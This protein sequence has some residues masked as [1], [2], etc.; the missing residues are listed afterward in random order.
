MTTTYT[1]SISSNFGGNFNPAQFQKEITNNSIITTTIQEIDVDDDT[2]DIVFRSSLSAPELT[3][4]ENLVS[5]YIYGADPRLEFV[6]NGAYGSIATLS[7]SQT[8][9][10]T[11]TL[12]D[13]TDTIVSQ[14]NTATISNKTL[15]SSN[16][17]VTKGF[18]VIVDF[19]GTGDYTSISAAFAA[20]NTSVFVR[21]GIYYEFDDIILPDG[22][23]LSGEANAQVTIVFIGNKGIKVDGS[24]G[25]KYTTGTI[26]VTNG[27]SQVIGNGTS[28]TN[29]VPGNFILIGN[30]FYSIINIQNDTN[31]TLTDIYRGATMENQTYVAQQMLTAIAIDN[32]II[33]GST[34]VGL[35]LRGLRH[36]TVRSTAVLG[37]SPNIQIVD[38]GDSS[39]HT[40]IVQNSI[41]HGI[42]LTNCY[43]FLCDTINVFNSTG[44]GIRL[45]GDSFSA[46][47]ETCSSSCNSGNGFCLEGDSRSISMTDCVSKQNAIEGIC[48]L[49]NT[50]QITIESCIVLNNSSHGIHFTGIGNIISDCIVHENGSNG[51]QCG[52]NGI[53]KGNQVDKNGG[54][55]IDIT[56]ENLCNINGNRCAENITNGIYCL[57][58]NNVLQGNTCVLNSSSGIKIISGSNNNIVS[59]NQLVNNITNNFIDGGTGTI[60]ANNIY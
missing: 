23:K 54:N 15:L 27:S 31:L 58:N 36:F 10:R 5:S 26:D 13:I 14:N 19:R 8:E 56:N 41:G 38:C 40:M 17:T 22:G 20:G 30:N 47:L 49:E 50:K 53:V 39:L 48:T 18:T 37:C 16:N 9:N 33:A 3:E 12:P 52:N 51:I 43:D 2:V 44:D 32:I 42:E 46:I 4:L 59:A 11:I 57:G 29:L 55:G 34:G 1:Y 35:F 28:F 60:I 24:G 25:V 45:N 21:I 6:T 7:I